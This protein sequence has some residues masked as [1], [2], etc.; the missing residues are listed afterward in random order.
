MGIVAEKSVFNYSLFSATRL[1]IIYKMASIIAEGVSSYIIE[2]LQKGSWGNEV[3][4]F[5]KK[6]V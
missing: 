1:N 6:S 5:D 2:N 4:I 3:N